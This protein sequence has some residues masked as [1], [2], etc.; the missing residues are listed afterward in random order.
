MQKIRDKILK[1]M[2]AEKEESLQSDFK[3]YVWF[4]LKEQKFLYDDLYVHEEV[5]RPMIKDGIIVF[6]GVGKHQ[7]EKMYKYGL[8]PKKIKK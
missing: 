2:R 1:S 3:L 6:E 5:V 4:H 8:K 7:N